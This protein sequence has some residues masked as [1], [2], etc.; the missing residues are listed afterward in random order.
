M[1]VTHD[2]KWS[3]MQP[4]LDEVVR[5][6]EG[7]RWLDISAEGSVMV[8]NI[9]NEAVISWSA[10]QDPLV[11]IRDWIEKKRPWPQYRIFADGEAWEYKGPDSEPSQGWHADGSPVSGNFAGCQTYR[12]VVVNDPSAVFVGVEPICRV[13]YRDREAAAKA[14]QARQA[15]PRTNNVETCSL[16]TSELKELRIKAAAYDRMMAAVKD[17]DA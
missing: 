15:D 13:E 4:L 14:E 9:D 10:D 1:T 6:E 11:V 5:L 12:Q 16:P 2:W 3:E 8:D 7:S 17:G